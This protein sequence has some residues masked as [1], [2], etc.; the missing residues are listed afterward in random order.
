VLQATFAHRERA[1]AGLPA[2]V[3]ERHGMR[4]VRCGPA[5]SNRI[6]LVKRC[7][8]ESGRGRAPI[9]AARAGCD[10][11]RG[12]LGPRPLFV[13]PVVPAPGHR[14]GLSAERPRIGSRRRPSTKDAPADLFIACGKCHEIHGGCER[15]SHRRRVEDLW[16]VESSCRTPLRSGAGNRH[17][18]AAH[19]LGLGGLVEIGEPERTY[20]VEPVKDPVPRERPAEPAEPAGPPP[21]EEPAKPEK[22]P[23]K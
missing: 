12:T 21:A 14:S 7:G 23:A 11:S 13:V 15:F 2:F 9:A 22:V 10:F 4:S 8:G 18:F 17:T 3:D 1:A 20:T 19:P 16:T 5:E 6:G